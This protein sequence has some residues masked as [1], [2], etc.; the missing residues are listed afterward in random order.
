MRN[1]VSN[2]SAIIFYHPSPMSFPQPSNNQLAREFL[3]LKRRFQGILARS[4][5]LKVVMIDS[6]ATKASELAYPPHTKVC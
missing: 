4:Q 3:G 2:A 5:A 6:D 1:T